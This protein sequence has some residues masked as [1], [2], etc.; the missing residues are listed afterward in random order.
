MDNVVL[1]MIMILYIMTE[2]AALSSLG[3]MNLRN[4]GWCIAKSCERKGLAAA[5]RWTRRVVHALVTFQ[6]HFGGE[7]LLEPMSTTAG[8]A[9]ERAAGVKRRRDATEV[10][11]QPMPE[12]SGGMGNQAPRFFVYK[13]ATERR[14]TELP[15]ASASERCGSVPRSDTRPSHE[16]GS[17]RLARTESGERTGVRRDFPDVQR[18]GRQQKKAEKRR[19]G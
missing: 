7:N 9:R 18:K 6:K 17:K 11:R 16:Q 12:R 4:S 15:R 8:Q 19:D 13:I 2:S 1:I 5:A 3:W 10:H 14:R